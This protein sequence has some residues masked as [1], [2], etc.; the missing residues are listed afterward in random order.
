[1]DTQIF[2]RVALPALILLFAVHRG[3][4]VSRHTASEDQTVK[5]REEGIA[6]RIAGLLGLLGFITVLAE[7]INPAWLNW[8]DLPLAMWVRWA[9]LGVAVS[10][11]VLLQW[12]QVTLGKSWSDTPRMLK[13]Q[14][15]ITSGPYRFVRHPI[16]TAFILILGS[17]LLIS[18][19]WLIGLCWAGM[20]IL[21]T[22]SRV[23]FEEALMLEYFGEQY[24]A[25]MKQTGRFLPHLG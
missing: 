18:S 25:Y 8:A 3:Y 17:T 5:R 24:R 19:N 12:A 22:A 7:V 21:E 13:Q 10:G 9:G 23:R 16:Y 4:Y 1:M 20:T 2:F 6:S 14:S 11:F 15:L